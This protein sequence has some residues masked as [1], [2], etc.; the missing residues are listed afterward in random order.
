V[1]RT[2]LYR[3]VWK[4]VQQRILAQIFRQIVGNAWLHT[5]ILKHY[6]YLDG[7]GAEKLRKVAGL[8]QDVALKRKVESHLRDEEKHAALFAQR[9]MELGGSPTFTTA[10]LEVSFL[11][12]FES[13]DFGLSEARLGEDRCLDMREISTFF[14][15]L[16]AEE[17]QG[18]KFFLAHLQVLDHDPR[19]RQL[20]E[21]VISDE[22]RHVAYLTEEL[23][24]LGRS[25][26]QPYIDGVTRPHRRHTTFEPLPLAQRL[27]R[28]QTLLELSHYQPVGTGMWVLWCIVSPML[29]AVRWR[30][31]KTGGSARRSH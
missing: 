1:L 26:S 21:E 5:S 18:L 15:L 23:E 2:S 19:T 12:G 17:E 24:R 4:S 3:P 14:V 11:R 31:Q 13:H 7:M 27:Q 8:L 25:G 20:L 29:Q 22:H 16:K 30:R 6:R 9:I 28:L 10:E